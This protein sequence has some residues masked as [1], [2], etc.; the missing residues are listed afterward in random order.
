M[1]A[2]S[3]GLSPEVKFSLI[4]SRGRCTFLSYQLSASRG[5]FFKL[6]SELYNSLHNVLCCLRSMLFI[7]M[8]VDPTAV[9]KK[10]VASLAEISKPY[11]PQ[12]WPKRC[13]FYS[14]TL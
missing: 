6:W 2:S 10:I 11:F 3:S 1:L 9:A 4:V 7:Y 14:C 8:H 12:L 13:R 5:S